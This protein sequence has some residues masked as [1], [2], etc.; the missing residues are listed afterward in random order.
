MDKVIKHIYSD[1]NKNGIIYRNHNNIHIFSKE[2]NS[3]NLFIYKT[4]HNEKIDDFQLPQY[5][6]NASPNKLMWIILNKL[7]CNK[8]IYARN[9]VLK[10]ISKNE[11]NTFYNKFHLLNSANSPINYG[12]IYDRELVA[13]CSFSKGRKMNRLKDNERSFELTRFCSKGNTTVVGGLSKLISLCI[14]E[15]KPKEIMTYVEHQKN[16]GKA[17][18]NLNFKIVDIKLARPY[19]VDMNT[20]ARYKKNEIE[21]CKNPNLIQITP[22]NNVKLLLTL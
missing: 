3:F 18:L 1:L 13:A 11:A 20:N 2:N 12:L 5:A 22:P 15:K 16:N 6:L 21:L 17:F 10:K 7:N 19:Y 9:C 14:H 8:K 4:Q